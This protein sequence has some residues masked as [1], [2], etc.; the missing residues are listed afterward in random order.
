MDS[1]KKYGIEFLSIF[2]AVISAFALNNWNDTRKGNIAEEKILTEIYDGLEKDLID[3][4]GNVDGH[5][6]GINAVIYFRNLIA[7]KKVSNDSLA[8]YY[9]TLTRNFFLLQNTSGYETLKSRGLEIIG[10]DSLRSSIISIYEYEYSILR[11]LEEAYSEMQFHEHYFKEINQILARSFIFDKNK[12]SIIG[13]ETP[14]K[15]SKNEEK[16]LLTYLWKIQTN[17]KFTLKC[18]AQ[19][20]EKIEKII[21]NNQKN[22]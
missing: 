18:Y 7:K 6:Q 17:R 4:N 2:I 11:K 14:L 1:W 13:I 10:D 5:K 12:K 20:K 8:Q 9:F 15:I 19:T 16:I 3:I 22:R 21:K